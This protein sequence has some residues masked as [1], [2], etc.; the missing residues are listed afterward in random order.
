MEV[1]M[2]LTHEQKWQAFINRDERYDGLFYT[3]VRT[4]GIFCK[5][6]CRARKPLEK[7]VI[8]YDDINTA[9]AEGFRPCKICEPDGNS[10]D[11][12]CQI[13]EQLNALVQRSFQNQIDFIAFAKQNGISSSHLV[14]EFKK[15]YKMTPKQ[16]LIISRIED[17]KKRL[18]ETSDEII[19]IAYDVGF[20]SSSSFY[21][22]FK[23][24]TGIAPAAYRKA[25]ESEY[26][27]D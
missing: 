26:T 24:S 6:S 13:L 8:F 10:A 22:H 25:L 15:K 9:K 12:L 3:G 19:K 5:P 7:N 11:N 1:Q 17:A 4:T 23:A 14:R 18:S 27:N 20:L 16:L 21:K 2:S